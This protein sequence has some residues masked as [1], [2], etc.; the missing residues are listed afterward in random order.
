MDQSVFHYSKRKPRRCP[1]CG[2]EHVVRIQYG[3]PTAEGLAA[4]DAGFVA[5]GGCVVTGV[6][7]SWQC[8]GCGAQIHREALRSQIEQGSHDLF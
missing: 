1:A 4:E 8:R 3:F 2:S 7:P 6:D 5:L